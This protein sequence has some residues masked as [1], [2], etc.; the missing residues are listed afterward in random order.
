MP[1]IG[2]SGIFNRGCF[3]RSSSSSLNVKSMTA[4]AGLLFVRCAEDVTDCSR[5]ERG[6]VFVA[7]VYMVDGVARGGG[8]RGG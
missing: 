1:T 8:G 2:V 7:A 5:E 3:L 6:G 4:L